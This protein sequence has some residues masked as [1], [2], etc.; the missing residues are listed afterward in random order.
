[1]I[2]ILGNSVP[3]DSGTKTLRQLH[4][5]DDGEER[6][7]AD[8]QKAVRQSLGMHIYLSF[9]VTDSPKVLISLGGSVYC[10]PLVKV[11]RTNA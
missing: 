6:F 1:L 8:L 3:A 11:I 5:E 2:S 4:V 9:P 10:L 7:Q